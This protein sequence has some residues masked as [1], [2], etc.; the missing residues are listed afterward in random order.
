MQ[1]YEGR[2]RKVGLVKG[3][4]PLPVEQYLIEQETVEFSQAHRLA[5]DAML[6]LID[7]TEHDAVIQLY[8]TGLTRCTLG[9]IAAF[10]KRAGD[11]T[12]GGDE[13]SLRVMEIWEYNTQTGEYETAV[14]FAHGAQ[15]NDT[16]V[17]EYG[18]T[19]SLLRV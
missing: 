19:E 8:I 11:C 4:H 1:S 2:I 18:F 14:A 12:V 5:Y 15:P 6:K 17:F 16:G 3:R 9:A 10:Q 7:S 13:T